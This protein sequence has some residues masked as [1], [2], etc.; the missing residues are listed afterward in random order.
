M[1]IEA[2]N[3]GTWRIEVKTTNSKN[4]QTIKFKSKTSNITLENILFG[5]V[6]LCSGQSNMEKPIGD[7]PNQRWCGLRC[8]G[9]HYHIVLGYSSSLETQRISVG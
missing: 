1:N 8:Q 4:P 3:K 2:D 7:K 5:E 9:D 6:W